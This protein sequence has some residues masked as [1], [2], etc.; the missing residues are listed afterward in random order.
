MKQ[1]AKDIVYGQAILLDCGY[2]PQS[3]DE[4]CPIKEVN[5]KA[6]KLF[7]GTGVSF[8]VSHDQGNFWTVVFEPN[9]ELETRG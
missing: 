9:D 2:G 6:P 7:G 5:Y 1:K 8:H 4:W 3:H